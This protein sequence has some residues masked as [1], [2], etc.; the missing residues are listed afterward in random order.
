MVSAAAALMWFNYTGF[1]RVLDADS[2]RRLAAAAGATSLCALLLTV[3]TVVHYSFGRRGSRVGTTL[4]LLTLI[5]SLLFPL[6]A[7]GWGRQRPL[8]S[9]S[10]DLS[11]SEPAES[12]GSRVTV[13]AVDGASLDFIEIAVANGRLPNLGRMLD[14]GASLHLATIRPTHAGAR[15]G[16]RWRPA[17]T[18]R[19]TASAPPPRIA[20]LAAASRSSC[21]RR[22]AS[23]TRWSISACSRRPRISRRRCAR[24]RCGPSSGACA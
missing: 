14:G 19:R 13:V 4:L 20:M 16:R 15:P 5:A 2:G 12:E 7:R 11:G 17:S 18:R 10:L 3:I 6:V 8:P 22:L 9:R 23:P 24:A 21:C 1:T